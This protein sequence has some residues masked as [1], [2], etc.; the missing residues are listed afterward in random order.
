MTDFAP[1][2]VRHPVLDHRTRGF[3]AR[4][5]CP[6]SAHDPDVEEAR[7][8]FTRLQGKDD[9]EPLDEEATSTEWFALPGGPTGHVR[10]QVVK[11][12]GSVGEI[13]VVLFLHGFGWVLGDAI[14]YERLVRAFALGTDAAVVF[15]EYERAPEARY[16]VAVEQC[17]AVA[18]WISEQG[19]E[20]GLDGSRMAAVGDSAGGNLVAALTLLAKERGGV[21]LLQQV[22]LCPVTDADFYTP[23]YQ[24]FAKG[25]FLGRETMRWFWDQ[26]LPDA[27]QRSEAT[28]SPLQATLEQLTGLPPALVVTSEADVVRD[29]GEAYAAKL[30][31]AGVPV[32]SMRYHGTIHGFMVLDP[33]RDT[34]TAH[35]ALVQALD[36]VHVALH[37]HRG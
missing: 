16:P 18:K 33:L 29:E 35:A 19:A 27:R 17:Y 2:S 28:A 24:Q 5:A 26:Y 23:S 32:V 37:R 11:P 8:D 3:L 25:Y 13:P 14:T 6:P 21:R 20:I 36:T 12:A 10:V 31:A 9:P 34:D 4:H 15:V 7:L 22:L 30:R 1:L